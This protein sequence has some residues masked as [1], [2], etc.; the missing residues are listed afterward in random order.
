[1]FTLVRNVT[2][3]KSS[4]LLA[5]ILGSIFI[6]LLFVFVYPSKKVVFEAEGYDTLYL[7]PKSFELHWVHSIEKEEWFEVYE[8]V[9]DGF[10][11]ATSHFKTFGAGV[12]ATSDKETYLED[13]YVVY[14][15]EDYYEEMHLNVSKNV[16]TRVIQGDD[17][18]LL[19]DWFDSYVSVSI[20]VKHVPLIFRF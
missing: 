2:M 15:I 8:V 13:G 12:P 10:L 3:M 6:V 9:D 7:S 5:T 4:K 11:L 1:M 18:F 20:R 14:P 19:Y 16:E 17:E